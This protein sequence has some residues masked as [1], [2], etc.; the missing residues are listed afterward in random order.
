M[1]D[2][3]EPGDVPEAEQRTEAAD[4]EVGVVLTRAREQRG[5]SVEQAAEALHLDEGI[6]V[7]LEAE[8][9]AEIG[10]PVFVRGHLKAY[11]RLLALDPQPLLAGCGYVAA[12]SD[13]AATLQKS[14]ARGGWNLNPVPVVAGALG[15]VLALA[16]GVYVLIGDEDTADVARSEP[17]EEP[18]ESARQPAPV[19]ASTDAGDP[20][21]PVRR[22]APDEPRTA[23]SIPP[24]EEPEVMT[25]VARDSQV[26]PPEPEPV[27]ASVE[28]EGAGDEVR[29]ELYFREESWAEISAR[30]RRILFGLQREGVRRE[31]TGRPPFKV[32]LGNG[33]AVDI[34]LDGEPFKVPAS[35][36]R[37]NVVRMVIDPAGEAGRGG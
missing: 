33:G 14:T 30:N 25:P 29:I 9:F 26:V 17:A 6:V 27:R 23:E 5:L 24:Q 22:S 8:R 2:N 37:G 7:A 31:L 21:V 4:T 10:A 12:E 16:L 15:V 34:L 3:P 20:A 36:R 28:S 32:L 11:A 19:A 35:A 13:I 1:A 18:A